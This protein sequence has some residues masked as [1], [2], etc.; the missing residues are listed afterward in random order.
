VDRS[1]RTVRTDDDDGD[2]ADDAADDDAARAPHSASIAATAT[3][4]GAKG[5]SPAGAR[6]SAQ[7]RAAVV[8]GRSERRTGHLLDG[9]GCRSGARLGGGSSGG[10]W[11]A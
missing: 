3:P 8:G 9:R 6:Y 7:Y 10:N 5:P 1:V 11:V 4:T 2:G